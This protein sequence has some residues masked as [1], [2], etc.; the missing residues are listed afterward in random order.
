MSNGKTSKRLKRELMANQDNNLPPQGGQAVILARQEISETF[1]GPLPD[2]IWTN[3]YTYSWGRWYIG[4][5][6]PCQIRLYQWGNSG[7]S[8]QFFSDGNKRF[9]GTPTK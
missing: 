2:P 4:L 1:Q 7:C 8:R 6:I 5:S 3:I 9:K